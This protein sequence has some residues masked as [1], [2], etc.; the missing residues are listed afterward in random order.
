[1][2]VITDSTTQPGN[3][4]TKQKVSK[5]ALSRGQCGRLNERK[6]RELGKYKADDL[7]KVGDFHH[8]SDNSGQKFTIR[9]CQ[10]FRARHR[11]LLVLW[12]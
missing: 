12:G 11:S 8:R 10:K 9:D 7:I 3:I 5:C 1:M 4:I 2:S 6:D